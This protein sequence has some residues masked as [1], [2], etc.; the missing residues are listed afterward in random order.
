[1]SRIGRREFLGA[2]LAAALPP[3]EASKVVIARDE[4][5]RGPEP[6]RVLKLLDRRFRFDMGAINS[7]HGVYVG[8]VLSPLGTALAV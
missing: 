3:P 5:S 4:T 6:A 1:M 8:H 7:Y 2:S